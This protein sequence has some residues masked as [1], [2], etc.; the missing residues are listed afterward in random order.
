MKF[1]NLCFTKVVVKQGIG[2]GLAGA[3]ATLATQSHAQQPDWQF[4]AGG[5]VAVSPEYI[6]A[7]DSRV[8]AL[9]F[10]EAKYQDW[11]TI[12]FVNGV[13]V[14]TKL[15]DGFSVGASIGADLTT[16]RAKDD[17]RLRTFTDIKAAPMARAFAEYRADDFVFKGTVKSRAGKSEGRG[18]LFELDA[19]YNIFADRS[20]ILAVGVLL[21]AMD[22]KYATNFFGVSRA[23]SVRSTLRQYDAKSGLRDTGVY[24]QS[25]YRF[26]DRWT[27][28]SRL[29]ATTLSSRASDSPIVEKKNQTTAIAFL[30]YSF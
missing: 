4:S 25:V 17:D 5:G 13:E 23:Q 2:I 26:T 11:L 12:N 15:A 6:G 24:V 27:L 3:F 1:L 16:R 21:T 10:F 22:S 18:T 29:Q 30:G 7:K 8:R 19:G 14:K 28:I 9:P 20:G